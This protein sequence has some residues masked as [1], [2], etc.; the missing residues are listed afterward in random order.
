MSTAISEDANTGPRQLTNTGPR[1]LTVLGK[2]TER[3]RENKQV[4]H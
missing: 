2:R 4:L 1:Q 3:R